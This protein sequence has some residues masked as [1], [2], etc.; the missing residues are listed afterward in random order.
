MV[1]AIQCLRSKVMNAIFNIKAEAGWPTVRAC[2]L[3]D[4]LKH[5]YHPNDKLSRV[6]MIK[7]LNK[8]KPKKERP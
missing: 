6:L 2:Q 7:K 3:F 1:Y 4:S 8:V 5:K